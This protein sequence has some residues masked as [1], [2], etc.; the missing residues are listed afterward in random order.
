MGSYYSTPQSVF[1]RT[2]GLVG[3]QGH[4]TNSWVLEQ[5]KQF[6]LKYG[7][8]DGDIVRIRNLETGVECD[9]EVFRGGRER[10]WHVYDPKAYRVAA[11]IREGNSIPLYLLGYLS[12]IRWEVKQGSER[13][14]GADKSA[15]NEGGCTCEATQR[16]IE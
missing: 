6:A 5:S 16:V 13:T 7:L 9:L 3:L 15:D 8:R 14:D 12:F 2:Q 10:P 1:E 4:E 11:G